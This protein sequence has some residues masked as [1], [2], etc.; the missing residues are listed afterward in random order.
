MKFREGQK[1]IVI[2]D[3]SSRI[4]KWINFPVVGILTFPYK[5]NSNDAIVVING[6]KDI[7]DSFWVHIDDIIPNSKF[8]RK[9]YGVE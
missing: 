9:L 1:V 8:F 5:T 3:T 6:G 4:P 7:R 2:K